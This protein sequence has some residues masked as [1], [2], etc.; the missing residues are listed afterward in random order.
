MMPLVASV[1]ACVGIPGTQCSFLLAGSVTGS[2]EDSPEPDEL[3]TYCT[4][5]HHPEITPQKN[6][7]ESTPEKCPNR[8]KFG[9]RGPCRI[10]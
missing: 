2:P 1:Q 7:N 5:L 3:S 6:K 10:N 8:L 4:N 9:Y